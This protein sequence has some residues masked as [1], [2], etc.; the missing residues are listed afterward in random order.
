MSYNLKFIQ[1]DINILKNS[2]NYSIDY[3]FF[4]Q[5]YFF[6]FSKILANLNKQSIQSF[7]NYKAQHLILF[8]TIY[9]CFLLN[10]KNINFKISEINSY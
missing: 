5:R 1:N 4:D 10:Q 6:Y 3:E 8:Q 9:K 7:I 2:K